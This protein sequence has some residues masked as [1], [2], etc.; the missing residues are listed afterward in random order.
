MRSESNFRENEKAESLFKLGLKSVLIL[1]TWY[2][3]IHPSKNINTLKYNLKNAKIKKKLETKCTV[4]LL[5]PSA[6]FFGCQEI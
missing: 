6:S 2:C 5:Y 3:D 1:F 4:I